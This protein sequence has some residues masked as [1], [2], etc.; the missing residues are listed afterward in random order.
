MAAAP[1][2]QT[3]VSL[4][5]YGRN[6]QPTEQ[7]TPAVYVQFINATGRQ[8]TR[9][10]LLG[11]DAQGLLHRPELTAGSYPWTDVRTTI[12]APQGAVRMALFLGIQP[13]RGELGFDDVNVKTADGEKP[14]GEV[15]ITEALPARIARERLR[16]IVYLDLCK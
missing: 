14:A 4:R 3:T 12:T 11:R 13:C 8:M 2:A 15:E 16:E 1:D 5:I 9:S 6:L 7:A 10:F